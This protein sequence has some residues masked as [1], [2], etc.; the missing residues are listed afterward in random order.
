MTLV[1]VRRTAAVLMCLALPSC[2][3]RGPDVNPEAGGAALAPSV[4]VRVNVINFTATPAPFLFRFGGLQLMDSIAPPGTLSAPVMSATLTVEPGTYAMQFFD[5]RSNKLSRA[6]LH[7]AD[8][9]GRNF[10]TVELV[11]EDADSRIFQCYCA[12]IYR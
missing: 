6:S 8:S 10:A 2:A 1:S 4:T 7:M 5:R 12:R 3:A 11:F 9:S